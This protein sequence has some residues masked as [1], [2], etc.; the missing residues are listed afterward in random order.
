VAAV[1]A[2]ALVAAGTVLAV[3]ATAAGAGGPAALPGCE[4]VVVSPAYLADGVAFCAGTELRFSGGVVTRT[5]R[6]WVSHDRARTWH[7]VAAN[8]LP[9]GD[10]LSFVDVAVSPAFADDRMVVLDLGSAGVFFS[11][12]AGGTFQTAPLVTGPVIVVSAPGDGLAVPGPAPAPFPVRHG[13]I[14]GVGRGVTPGFSRSVAFD[15]V[16]MNVR[17]VAGTDAIDQAFFASPDYA[18]DGVAFATGVTGTT[19]V[20][21]QYALYACDAGF[22]CRTRLFA[23]PASQRVDRLT[24]AADYAKSGTLYATTVDYL[25]QQRAYVSS[26]RGVHFTALKTL[27]AAMAEVY[28]GGATGALVLT[29]GRAGS[30]TVLARVAGG[31]SKPQPP[32]ERVYRSDDGGHRW[33]LVAF[34]R[35]ADVAG[36]RGTIPYALYYAVG[37][38]GQAPTGLLT[39]APDGRLL[40]NA[41]HPSQGGLFVWCSADGGVHW[42][43]ACR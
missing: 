12:D 10:S 19:P 6:V 38:A 1:R 23:F 18:T 4:R 39:M 14:V 43:A 7:S 36:P 20:T 26:D 40:A 29:A 11:R 15:P 27:N 8:G 17:L 9:Q 42:T 37:L 22:T 13:L 41:R 16:L 34:G 31:V 24:F 33:R 35:Y 28:R 21:M 5:V 3:V 32:G 2:R 25:Q 30:R